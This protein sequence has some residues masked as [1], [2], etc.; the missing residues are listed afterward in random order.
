MCTGGVRKRGQESVGRQWAACVDGPATG[1]I[2]VVV[3]FSLANHLL[4][5]IATIQDT[6]ITIVGM[7]GSRAMQDKTKMQIGIFEVHYHV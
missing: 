2:Q 6:E 7:V 1:L 3:Q 5:M 4:R